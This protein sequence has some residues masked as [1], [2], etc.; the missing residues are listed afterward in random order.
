MSGLL[1]MFETGETFATTTGVTTFNKP[2]NIRLWR[3]N[4][5][6]TPE[7][8]TKESNNDKVHG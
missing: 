7:E 2:P 1:D 4:A 3:I 6:G 5:D 8:V